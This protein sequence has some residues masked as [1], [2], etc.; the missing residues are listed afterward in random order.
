MHT[1]IH[2]ITIEAHPAQLSAAQ[3][4]AC[5]VVLCGGWCAV[6]RFLLRISANRKKYLC[7]YRHQVHACG[8]W[9]VIL[10]HGALGILQVARLHLWFWNILFVCSVPCF[11][12]SERSGRRRLLGG[13]PCVP[14]IPSTSRAALCMDCAFSPRFPV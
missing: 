2:R 8:F 4:S 12:V 6:L 1:R 9:V 13:A 3:C 7:T 14:H 11:V 5:C 10:M